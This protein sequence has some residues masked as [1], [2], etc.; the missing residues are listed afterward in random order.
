MRDEK[1]INKI[2]NL[3]LFINR[4]SLMEIRNMILKSENLNE[5]IIKNKINE[6]FNS[7][8]LIFDKKNINDDEKQNLKKNQKNLN[9]LIDIERMSK[10]IKE[11]RDDEVKYLPIFFDFRGRNYF[12]DYLSPTFSR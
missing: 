11:L 3:K 4:E 8:K 6:C 5:I 1:Y 10:M 12:D 9:K 2:L 7:I